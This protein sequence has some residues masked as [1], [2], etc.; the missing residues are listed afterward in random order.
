MDKEGFLA[1]IRDFKERDKKYAK[2]FEGFSGRLPRFGSGSS[3]ESR[4]GL[5]EPNICTQALPAKQQFIYTKQS[6]NM[7]ISRYNP[8]TA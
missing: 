6:I 1:M 7:F 3:S 2:L 5:P 8:G 4:R